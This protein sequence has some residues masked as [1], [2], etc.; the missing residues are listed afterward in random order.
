MPEAK[1]KEDKQVSKAA[2]LAALKKKQ[3]A[4]VQG[5][6]KERQTYLDDEGILKKLGIS[7]G[8]RKTY[9]ARVSKIVFSFAKDDTNRPAFRFFYVIESDDPRVNGTVVNN[10]Y[11][12]EQGV[13]SNGKVWQT[14][15]EAAARI[16]GEF[17]GIGDDTMSWKDPIAQGVDAAEYH[18]KNRTPISLTVSAKKNDKK[19]LK[20]YK[21]PSPVQLANDNSDLDQS[22]DEEDFD[23]SVWNGVWIEFEH[24]A[25]EGKVRMKITGHTDDSF[26]GVDE[27]NEE[28][29]G[30]YAIPF[31]YSFEESTNQEG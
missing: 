10:Y 7:D 20:M 2:F 28:W 21:Y 19:E 12:L 5:A 4:I 17:Q 9:N 23:P 6:K 26:T 8:E 15:E 14:E 16:M 1:Q 22:S 11:I 3:G 29:S 30:D 31:E 24:E 18:T 27:N 25:V 13:K